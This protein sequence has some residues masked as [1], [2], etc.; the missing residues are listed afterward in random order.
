ML[1]IPA[2]DLKKGEVVRLYKGRF[3]KISYYDVEVEKIFREYL[4]SGVKRI[5]IVLLYG[6]KTG[7]IGKEEEEKI[8]KIIEIKEVNNRKDCGF[9]RRI[10]KGTYR[11]FF[12]FRYCF[13]RSG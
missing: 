5:H 6:A 3:D 9:R 1:I 13:C 12:T 8:R 11:W 10:E 7:E 2:I 4:K